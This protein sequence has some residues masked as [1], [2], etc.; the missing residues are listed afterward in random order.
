MMFPFPALG[1]ETNAT[2]QLPSLNMQKT[3][4]NCNFCPVLSANYA[5]R[6]GHSIAVYKFCFT[7]VTSAW[8][9]HMRMPVTAMLISSFTLFAFKCIFP[10]ISKEVCLHL[11]LF[12]NFPLH[13]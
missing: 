10:K 7:V 8:H 4:V 11:K 3:I 13:S 12:G 6:L 9:F 2:P 1:V 5:S